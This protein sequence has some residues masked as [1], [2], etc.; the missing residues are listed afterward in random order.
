MALAFKCC[1][2]P[3]SNWIC[4]ICHNAFHKSCRSRIARGVEIISDNLMLCSTQ[5]SNLA[6]ESTDSNPDIVAS[7]TQIVK[8][9]KTEICDKTNYIDRLKQEK[10]TLLEEA[11]SSEDQ[12]V[13]ENSTLKQ[14]LAQ[15]TRKSLE[16]V[17]NTP[18]NLA[19]SSTQTPFQGG[20]LLWDDSQTDPR[21]P[22]NTDEKRQALMIELAQITN[23]NRQMVTRIETLGNDNLF[24]SNEL[25]NL[26][27][28]LTSMHVSPGKLNV[29][30]S[31]SSNGAQ[32]NR[33]TVC[34]Q[35]S[36]DSDYDSIKDELQKSLDEL[37]ELKQLEQRMIT[38]IQVLNEDNRFLSLELE[39][40]KQLQF[41]TFPPPATTEVLH[42]V[43]S[44]DA[45]VTNQ[46]LF[47]ELSAADPLIASPKKYPDAFNAK[48]SDVLV[49][50]DSSARGIVAGLRN[51]CPGHCDY[52]IH[53]ESHP[54][55]TISQMANRIFELTTNYCWKDNVIVCMDLRSFS[56]VSYYHLS[57]LFSVGR[58]TNLIFSLSYSGN[59]DHYT[60]SNFVYFCHR[61]LKSQ[62]ASIRIFDNSVIGGKFRLSK[63]KLCN[64]LFS[65][66]KASFLLKNKFASLNVKCHNTD[67][68]DSLQSD[69]DVGKSSDQIVHDTGD[70][71]NKYFLGVTQVN[72]T[73][74]L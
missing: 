51:N 4:I 20:T 26:K 23:L 71:S 52:F 1:K 12:L 64:Y 70:T 60:Y 8:E 5:C 57:K 62:N 3:Q 72:I 58:Y 13:R 55:Y 42:H 66:V 43:N 49:F 67:G 59:N 10:Q 25:K 27:E 30:P 54:G 6:S 9:L 33:S 47:E 50:G 69:A 22:G 45:C 35:C 44:E 2:K 53:G 65:Y 74:E 46:S 7:L 48:R 39:R 19:S 18:G 17:T 28:Q 14:K 40:L 41:C 31:S 63:K 16:Q 29:A 34:V 56:N 24:L 36:A 11:E 73:S 38:S 15:F 37:S 61:F 32:S 21:L 68:E